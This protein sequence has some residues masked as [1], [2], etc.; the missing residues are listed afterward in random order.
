MKFPHTLYLMV[1][2]VL[3]ALTGCKKTGTHD[4][5]REVYAPRYA[6]GFTVSGADGSD[7]RLITVSN[8]WQGADSV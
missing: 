5:D 3:F 2:A 4:F 8:P 1:F 7:S 6:S